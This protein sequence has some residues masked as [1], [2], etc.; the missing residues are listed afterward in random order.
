M[1]SQNLETFTEQFK[2]YL[3][4]TSKKQ[5]SLQRSIQLGELLIKMRVIVLQEL[6][7]W[8]DWL[9]DRLQLDLTTAEHF[10]RRYEYRDELAAAPGIT[11]VF[12]ADNFI[13]ALAAGLSP[14][15]LTAPLSNR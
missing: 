11:S 2:S 5:L 13:D 15:S 4:F 3:E 14:R 8:H 12:D 6:L 7:D 10:M 9:E 1:P